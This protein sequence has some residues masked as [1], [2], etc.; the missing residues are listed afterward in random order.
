MPDL[1]ILH[2]NDLHG[3]L[4]DAVC[5]TII[6]EK[7][8]GGRVLLLDGGD[9][10]SSGNVYF[11]PGGEPILKRMTELG[12]HAMAMGNREFHFMEAGLK[13]K[14]RQAGFPILAANLQ[15]RG[16]KIPDGV[17]PSVLFQL[18]GLRV[19]VFGLTVPMITQDM[20]I[21]MLSPYCFDNPITTAARI[22]PKLRKE[23]DFLIALTHI[24]FR[25][26]MELATSVDGIDLIVGGH[27][28]NAIKE[29]EYF[30]R[31]AVV[32]AGWWG[33]Y[34]GRT[35]IELTSDDYSD[36]QITTTLIDMRT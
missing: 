7:N 14:T 8:V 9:A 21:R 3:K 16:D 6:R 5:K 35:E 11:R 20:T 33:H 28:H 17:K 26:D 4:T 36:T 2:T 1:T 31:T 22:V 13:S 19:G 25:Q 27:S 32:Q 23:C 15:G 10:V 12:Y 24:G 30:G 29:V 18:D 34:L